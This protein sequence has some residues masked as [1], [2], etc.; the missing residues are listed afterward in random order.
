MKATK[1]SVALSRCQEI[2]KEKKYYTILDRSNTILLVLSV[3]TFLG[4][5][6]FVILSLCNVFS[7][8]I[9]EFRNGLTIWFVFRSLRLYPRI[10]LK[11]RYWYGKSLISGR[12]LISLR[13]NPDEICWLE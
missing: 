9:T 10:T 4:I 12:K 2:Q 6:V 11:K 1:V 8:N 13:K 5:F 7:I 3:F